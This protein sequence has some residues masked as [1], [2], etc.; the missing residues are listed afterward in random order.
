M[1]LCRIVLASRKTGVNV[2]QYHQTFPQLEN[3][4]TSTLGEHSAPM[5]YPNQF[6]I[7]LT[8]INTGLYML[9]MHDIVK[10]T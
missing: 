4:R 2:E 3:Q 8:T 10:A 1:F 7:E 6:T 9:C 5:F